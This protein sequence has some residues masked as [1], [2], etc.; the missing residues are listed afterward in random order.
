MKNQYRLYFTNN[1]TAAEPGVRLPLPM[2]SSTVC[3]SSS[4]S[5]LVYFQPCVR[6]L[7]LESQVKIPTIFR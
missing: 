1:H 3:D 2:V 6:T 7:W 4:G 5:Y